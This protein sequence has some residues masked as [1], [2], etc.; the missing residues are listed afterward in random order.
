M[1]LLAT[2]I[3]AWLLFLTGWKGLQ[4]PPAD[5]RG[6]LASA[7]MIAAGGLAVATALLAGAWAY[8][9]LV[10][11]DAIARRLHAALAP[12]ES[13]RYPRRPDVERVCQLGEVLSWVCIFS[14]VLGVGAITA[15]G[16][17]GPERE[18]LPLFVGAAV[19]AG[20][21]VVFAIAARLP[22][23][24]AAATRT[25]ALRCDAELTAHE[26]AGPPSAPHSDDQLAD[27]APR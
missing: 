18:R 22:A 19:A 27:P 10:L 20:L 8:R 6:F 21:A 17:V 11:L 25:L 15:Y 4:G 5:L 7:G 13:A 3:V 14:L 12:E 9:L 23:R 2:L 16:A 24:V 26:L 1:L